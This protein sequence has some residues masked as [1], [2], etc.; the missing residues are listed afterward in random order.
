[1][2]RRLAAAQ[3]SYRSRSGRLRRP[4]HVEPRFAA[5]HLNLEF[6]PDTGLQVHVGFILFRSLLARFGEAEIRMRAVLGGVIPPDLIVGPAVGGPEI[7]VF[8]FSVGLEP[9]SDANE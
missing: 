8:V 3:A 2:R 9:K 5:F 1:M 7:D 4:V 6:R